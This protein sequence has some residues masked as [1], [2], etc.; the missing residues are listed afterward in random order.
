MKHKLVYINNICRKTLCYFE[1][2][3]EPYA[4]SR[5]LLAEYN[6]PYDENRGQFF[7]KVEKDLINISYAEFIAANNAVGLF[8]RNGFVFD[9]HTRE[10]NHLN[11]PHVHVSWVDGENSV[12][13]DNYSIERRNGT[14]SHE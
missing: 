14:K 4:V 10:S 11:T 8:C 13:L 12:R 9:I 7:Q 3:D 6:H 1:C 2:E 5:K